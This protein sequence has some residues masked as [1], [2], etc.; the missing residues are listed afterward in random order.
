MA[1]Q[2]M[3]DQQESLSLSLVYKCAEPIINQAMQSAYGLKII[4]NKRAKQGSHFWF[5][6]SLSLLSS[7]RHAAS[8][9]PSTLDASQGDIHLGLTE[10]SCYLLL[11]SE[12]AL[13]SPSLTISIPNRATYPSRHWD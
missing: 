13:S 7:L 4:D 2:P 11:R 9:P 3:A 6:T 10:S 5:P 12:W 1:G 8:G